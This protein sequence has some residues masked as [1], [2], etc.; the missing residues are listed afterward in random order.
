MRGKLTVLIRLEFKMLWS[1]HLSDFKRVSA[2]REYLTNSEQH[3]SHIYQLFLFT[4][5]ENKPP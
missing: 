4:V 2:N 3:S 1:V 5:N